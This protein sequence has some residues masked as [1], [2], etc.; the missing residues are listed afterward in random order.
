MMQKKKEK[1]VSS[2][3]MVCKNNTGTTQL[4][5]LNTAEATPRTSPVRIA[6]DTMFSLVSAIFTVNLAKKSLLN[7]FR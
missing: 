5:M 2:E 1:K 7:T 6:Y 4:A 3:K